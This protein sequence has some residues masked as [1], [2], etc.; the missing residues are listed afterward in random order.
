MSFS[1]DV[2]RA[3]WSKGRVIPN[4]DATNGDGMILVQL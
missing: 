2:I 3:V 1:N 4:F